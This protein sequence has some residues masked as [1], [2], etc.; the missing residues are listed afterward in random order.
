METKFLGTFRGR[1]IYGNETAAECMD[2]FRAQ[3]KRLAQENTELQL[4][5]LTTNH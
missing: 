5:C 4:R 2:Y 3:E 1:E